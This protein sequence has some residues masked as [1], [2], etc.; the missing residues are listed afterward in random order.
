MSTHTHTHTCAEETKADI[1]RAATEL[2]ARKGYGQTGVREIAAEAGVSISMINYHFGSKQGILKEIVTRAFDEMQ[3]I[4]EDALNG[5]GSLD[6][7]VRAMTRGMTER[8][9][10]HP[11]IFRVM[12]SLPMEDLPKLAAIAAEYMRRNA[13]E[14]EKSLLRECAEVSGR[15]MPR[16]IFGPMLPGMIM[17]HFH[18]KATSKMIH[19]E[20]FDEA[21]YESYPDRIADLILYGL[22]GR[23]P[24]GADPVTD[25]AAAESPAEA[26]A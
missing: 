17:G 1:L 10:N 9:L 26:T 15:D 23:R 3:R 14:M 16:S 8:A 2:I 18:H 7:R 4:R 11:D 21:F 20:V 12:H 22:I 19:G 13:R 6:E 5:P 25:R 24:D